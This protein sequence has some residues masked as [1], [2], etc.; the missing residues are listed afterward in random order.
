MTIAD[1]IA[2]DVDARSDDLLAFLG[3]LVAAES[4]NPPGDTRAVAALVA[5]RLARAGIAHRIVARVPE[6]PNLLAV[7]DSGR[8]GPH[9]VLNVHL[10][11]IHPGEVSDWSVPLYEATHRDGRILGLGVG[12][13]K[14]AV[15]AMTLAFELLAARRGDWCGRVTFTAVA[16]ETVFGPDGAAFLLGTEPDLL[17]DAVICGE[18]PGAM[19]LGLAE[20]GVLWLALDAAAPSAQGM[21]ARPRSSATTR[22]AAAIVELDGWND[23][24]ATAPDAIAAVAAHPERDG[25]RLSVNTGTLA[26][27]RFVSQSATRATAEIDFRIPPGLDIATIESRVDAVLAG[28]GGLA[29]RRIKGWEPNWTAADSPIVAAVA[30]AHHAVRGAPA[31]PVVRLPASDASRW[32]QRGIPAVCY[33]PQADLVSGVDDWVHA[34]DVIDCAKIYTVAALTFLAPAPSA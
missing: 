12:N 17:G 24:L 4:P 23:V 21:L 30:A 7:A 32:R 16:D 31:V 5:D 34:R 10:D 29:R 22:L 19:G 11:T 25:L 3:R 27:G 33:G 9:L 2:A 20:K 1:A 26:G 15:A 14:G 8:P 6:K 18:G 28:I 13:M